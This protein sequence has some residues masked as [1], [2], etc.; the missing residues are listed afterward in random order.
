[1]NRHLKL[2][3]NEN[4]TICKSAQTEELDDSFENFTLQIKHILKEKNVN[5]NNK[6]KSDHDEI[7][8]T[9]DNDVNS[10]T[11][12]RTKNNNK[13]IYMAN[14]YIKRKSIETI[15]EKNIKRNKRAEQYKKIITNETEQ[16]KKDKRLLR[17]NLYQEKKVEIK[18]TTQLLANNIS[19]E[20]LNNILLNR[21]LNET[22]NFPP[23]DL[24]FEKQKQCYKKTIDILD[25]K[26]LSYEKVCACCSLSFPC[27][28]HPTFVCNLFDINDLQN[29]EILKCNEELYKKFPNQFFY[30]TF[31]SNALNNLILN[32]KGIINKENESTKLYLC[33]LCSELLKKKKLPKMAIANGFFIGELMN[34]LP[35]LTWLEQQCISR[36]KFSSCVIKLT[37]TYGSQKGFKGHL[38]AKAQNPDK[39]LTILPQRPICLTEQ[40]HII[41]VNS[42][43]EIEQLTL[44]IF[45]KIVKVNREKIKIWL[46]YLKKYNHLY[47]NVEINYNNINLFPINDVPVE[48]Q[49]AFTNVQDFQNNDQKAEK[50][51]AKDSNLYSD[52][53]KNVDQ[54]QKSFILDENGSTVPINAVREYLDHTLSQH[55]EQGYEFEEDSIAIIPGTSIL[56]T[57]NIDFFANA[58]PTLFPH[59]IGHPY[60]KKQITVNF[61]DE[62][63]HRLLT[64]DSKFTDHFLFQFL[65]YN[66]INQKQFFQSIKYRVQNMNT[67][68][69]NRIGNLT[70]EK[71]EKAM[72][73]H[74][75]NLQNEDSKAIYGQ[76]LLIGSKGF[77]FNLSTI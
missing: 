72:K 56:E 45:E 27:L 14:Y 30:K 36:V 37:K 70:V 54:C 6:R 29:L 26:H 23:I 65:S 73:D 47:E 7:L 19:L 66:I 28:A 21:Q 31:P 12:L 25:L 24:N 8:M 67:S 3:S 9:I 42:K 35:E 17:A 61:E 76:L 22:N 59:G 68:I 38:I 10:N 16:Q 34:D 32:K 4:E 48:I 40:L 50:G 20:I 44:S 1:M 51:V 60:M 39:L 13:K 49:T 57:S 77:F 74:A 64:F 52:P 46:E 71:L 62:I 53:I 41:F 11:N 69:Q 15:E 75:N 5:K 2:K 43:K 58:F 63:Q 33:S 18:K 55:V